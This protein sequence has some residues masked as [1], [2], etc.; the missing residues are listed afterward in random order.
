MRLR[1]IT[2]GNNKTAELYTKDKQ[3][4]LGEKP[5]NQKD[6]VRLGSRTEIETEVT[7]KDIQAKTEKHP[8]VSS[9]TTAAQT[10]RPHSQP[11]DKAVP[12]EEID[13]LINHYA[14]LNKQHR[15]EFIEWLQNGAGVPENYVKQN[16]KGYHATEQVDINDTCRQEIRELM[17]DDA[18]MFV[19][20]ALSEDFKEKA[21]DLFMRSL[22]ERMNE[23]KTFKQG[24]Q[25]LLEN[26][27]PHPFNPPDAVSVMERLALRVE[28][29][30]EKLDE[31][32]IHKQE[33]RRQIS[34][35]EEALFLDAFAGKEQRSPRKSSL[36]ETML[37]PDEANADAFYNQEEKHINPQVRRYLTNDGRLW[38]VP[39]LED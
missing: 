19:D 10:L 27:S 13:K 18:E 11:E 9:G 39:N 22:Q 6:E 26:Y 38:G 32:I 33:L 37:T 20:G 15:R 21:T 34:L 1:Q 16:R 8:N 5:I 17:D 36:E 30:Q 2:E 29:L 14:G 3:Q 12:Q 25:E 35:Q 23:D 31:A 7:M 4:R 24:V 28:D